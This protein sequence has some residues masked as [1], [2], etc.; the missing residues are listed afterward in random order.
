MEKQIH[1]P[2]A[3]GNAIMTLWVHDGEQWHKTPTARTASNLDAYLCCPGPGLADVDPAKLRRPGVFVMGVNTSYPKIKPDMW[4][5]MDRP[6]CFPLELFSE[7]FI[8]VLSAGM[9]HELVNGVPILRYHNTLFADPQKKDDGV[10]SIFTLKNHNDPFIWTGN[11]IAVALHILVWMGF[12]RIHFVGCNLGGDKDYHDDRV[13]SDENRARNRRMYD[14]VYEEIKRIAELGAMNGIEF[15]SCTEESRLNDFLSYLPLS[16]AL[17]CSEVK[18][19]SNSAPLHCRAA[20]DGFLVMADAGADW[21]FPW[22]LKNFRAHNPNAELAVCDIGMSQH[23]RE[24]ART[25][26]YTYSIGPKQNRSG[27]W[28]KPDA[29]LNS[30][31]SN[32]IF[33]DLDVEVLGNLDCMFKYMKEQA[34]GT[35]LMTSDKH[36]GHLGRYAPWNTGVIGINSTSKKFL[37]AWIEKMNPKANHC[38]QC[39]LGD[40]Q[41]ISPWPEEYQRLRLDGASN[42]SPLLMHWT[43]P[44]GKA[45]IAR[46]MAT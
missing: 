11:T 33:I 19:N 31:F 36:F 10:D 38:D 1:K 46:S 29:L 25:S 3:E 37:E 21:M 24:L 7:P 39:S 42:R 20:Q 43:G 15:V 26:G 28:L 18:P 27:W 17:E 34:K 44:V 40:A 6:Q 30:P 32:T 16:L 8:K 22:W 45:T 4:V 12:R 9:K 41:G 35:I 23:M 14:Q 2:R 13:L 5:G